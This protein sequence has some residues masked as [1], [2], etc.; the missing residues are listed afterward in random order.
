MASIEIKN[1]NL[2]VLIGKF[3]AVQAIKSSFEIPLSCVKEAYEDSDFV[4]ARNIGFRSPGTGFPGL[5]ARGTF[6]KLG[7]KALVFWGKGQEVVV[8]QLVGCKWDKLVI[9]C[10]DAKALA[11][12]IN[13]SISKQKI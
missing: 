2:R 1:S 5:V 9:G 8:I 12:E 4:K 11:V 7:E 3:E 13:S 6:R 10:A